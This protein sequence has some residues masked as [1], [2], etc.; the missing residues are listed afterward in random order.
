[1]PLSLIVDI[2]VAFLLV[3]T[4]AYAIVLNKRLVMLR[5]DKAVLEKLAETFSKSTLRAEESIAHLKTTAESIQEHVDRAQSLRDDLAFLIDRGGK[6]ADQLE[7]VVR[8]ARK[9]VGPIGRPASNTAGT[10]VAQK[11]AIQAQA[12]ARD[13]APSATDKSTSSADGRSEA[14]RELLKALESAR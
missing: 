12:A 13:P 14:E 11:T 4:I 5:R 10:P 9:K 7:D 8:E 6:A 2:S 1:M 3:V